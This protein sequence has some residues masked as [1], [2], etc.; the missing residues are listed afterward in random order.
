M[1]LEALELASEGELQEARQIISS[2]RYNLLLSNFEDG[3][4]NIERRAGAYV[5]ATDEKLDWYLNANLALTIAGIGLIILG[6]FAILRPAK[7]WG[8]Q[9]NEA[10]NIAESAT[11][12]V[13][14]KQIELLSLNVQLFE[15][16][17]RDPL[18]NLQT[19]L[20]LNEDLE[21]L[22]QRTE[23]YGERYCAVMCDIDHFKQYNDTYGHLAGD[24]V[25]RQVANA[26]SSVCRGGDQLYRFGG[27]EFVIILSDC[28]IQRGTISADRYRDAVEALR[29]TH[30]G[31]PYG[32][33]TVSLGVAALE[34][35][36]GATIQSWL[37]DA[38]VALYEAKRAGRNRVVGSQAAM[39]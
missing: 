34:P 20:K 24:D 17:R 25:L 22:W 4:A 23:R 11:R 33:V 32:S 16:A 15:Q 35:G 26:L 38:D 1:E 9:L 2:P 13:E 12:E 30:S 29:V 31:S 39:T 6:W 21:S 8:H 14:E 36:E 3:L 28:S 19:R 10:R 27:E 7:L 37:T 18:T 5:A